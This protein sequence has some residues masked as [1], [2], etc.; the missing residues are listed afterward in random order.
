M[1]RSYTSILDDKL[2]L[3][4]RDQDELIRHYDMFL[5]SVQLG[6]AREIQHIESLTSTD[7]KLLTSNARAPPSCPSS[8]GQVPPSWMSPSEVEQWW[9]TQQQGLEQQREIEN[10]HRRRQNK[11]DEKNKQEEEA[12]LVRQVEKQ[13]SMERHER[14][15]R[16]REAREKREK[17]AK[18]K[19]DREWEAREKL[20]ME[21]DAREKREKEAREKRE[22]EVKEKEA[23]ARQEQVEE[24]HYAS[25]VSTDVF[26][27]TFFPHS[28]DLLVNLDGYI[29]DQ[30]RDCITGK[31]ENDVKRQLNYNE[32]EYFK[33]INVKTEKKEKK[34]KKELPMCTICHRDMCGDTV[35]L[36]CGHVYHEACIDPWLR[37]YNNTCPICRE[38]V[39]NNL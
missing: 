5:Q 7:T 21:K 20:E 26:L 6:I 39:R 25:Y 3:A 38:H 19:R 30:S 36:P 35:A 31:F 28:K 12:R 15:R 29:F 27:Q 22:K 13:K 32:V 9:R 16:E 24:K 14:E 18:E 8:S 11:Q 33:S 17:E 34:E 10:E 1:M 23:R 2:R 37:N 4:D